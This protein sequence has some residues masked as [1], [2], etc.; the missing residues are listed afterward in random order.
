M[1][2]GYIFDY[3][4]TL[5]TAGCHWGKML[6]H[7]YQKEQV[8]VSEEQ[9]RDA[10]V[11][12][13]RTLGSNPIIQSHYTFHKT[14][15]VKIRLEMEYLCTSGSWG[16]YEKEFQEK[17]NAVLE[18]LYAQVKAI[19]AH[20]GEVLASLAK[21]YPLVLVSNF[22][23]NIEVVLKEFQLDG[24]FKD[25]VESAVIGIRKPDPR[26]FT[27][28]VRRLALKPDEVM[29]V[30]DSFYKDIE[31]ALK[32]GCHATWFKGEGW[33]SQTYD[34]TVPDRVITDLAQLLG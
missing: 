2:K 27:E 16:A 12:G 19:T 28:G 17:H 34:E 30:G 33:T 13:E 23:G 4:G 11:Y 24:Y 25:V 1:I 31:P 3:G 22:Y 7:A 5:D 10:Y 26:I 29:V 8:P 21:T 14:L 20:S 9:F 6:W 18:T 32:A 15:D